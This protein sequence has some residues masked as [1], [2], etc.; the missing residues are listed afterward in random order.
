MTNTPPSPIWARLLRPTQS[1]VVFAVLLL[2]IGSALLASSG[3]SPQA[4][5]R[6]SLSATPVPPTA[7]ASPAPT[8]NAFASSGVK[9]YQDAFI[10]FDYPD[11]WTVQADPRGRPSYSLTPGTLTDAQTATTRVIVQV[12]STSALLQSIQ[13]ITEKSTPREILNIAVGQPQ[14]GAPGIVI[15]DVKAG[16]LTGAGFHQA[17]SVDQT[18]GQPTNLETE[19]WLLALDPTHIAIVQANTPSGQWTTK[20]APL[21]KRLTDSLTINV[22]AAIATPVPTSAAPTTVAPTSAAT[23]AGP[24]APPTQAATGKP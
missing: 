11:Q 8:V 6:A 17:N 14:P 20:M 10:K 7:T 16:T 1:V 19:L 3:I 13:G 4:S 15:N 18:T 23:M 9:T 24:L 21:Y 22:A 2:L 12:I 5:V